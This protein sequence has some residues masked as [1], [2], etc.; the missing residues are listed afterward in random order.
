MMVHVE[1]HQEICACGGTSSDGACGGT[2]SDL[3]MWR[4]IK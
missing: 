3:C 4:D 2:S 1:G